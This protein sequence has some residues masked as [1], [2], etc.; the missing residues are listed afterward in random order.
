MPCI[1]IED[2]VLY[3]ILFMNSIGFSFQSNHDVL[4]NSYKVSFNKLTFG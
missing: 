4:I 3:E 2:V 1:W